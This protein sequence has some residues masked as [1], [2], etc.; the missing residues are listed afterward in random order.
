MKTF[1][2]LLVIGL[3][4]CGCNPSQP[5][6]VVQVKV[7]SVQLAKDNKTDSMWTSQINDI[8]VYE[9]LDTHERIQSPRV[10]GKSNDV[11]SARWSELPKFAD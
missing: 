7:V 5:E 8:V 2:S 3:V 11:F 1:L 10:L 6:P 9:R 4:A